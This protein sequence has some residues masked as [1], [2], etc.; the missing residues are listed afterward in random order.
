M[1]GHI[2]RQDLSGVIYRDSHANRLDSLR[3]LLPARPGKRDKARSPLDTSGLFST[4]MYS[5]LTSIYLKAHRTEITEDTLTSLMSDRDTTA[6]NCERFERLWKAETESRGESK[7]SL[8]RVIFRFIR[9]RFLAASLVLVCG[10][11]SGFLLTAFVLYLAI[12]YLEEPGVSTGYSV[13]LAFALFSSAACRVVGMNFMWYLNIRTAGRLRNALMMILYKKV[14]RL[15]SSSDISVGE[16][17][18]ICVNDMQRLYDA[19]TFLPVL[20][21]SPIFILLILIGCIL[22][23]GVPATLMGTIMLLL[24]IAIQG[25][26]AKINIRL[27]QKCVKLTDQRTRLMNEVLN[28][29][30]LIKMYAWEDIFSSNLSTIRQQECTYLQRAGYLG[31][32]TLGLVLSACPAVLIAAVVGNRLLGNDITAAQAFTLMQLFGSFSII[33][34]LLPNAIKPLSESVVSIQRIQPIL[35]MTESNHEWELPSDPGHALVIENASFSWDVP[36]TKERITEAEINSNTKYTLVIDDDMANADEKNEESVNTERL[37]SDENSKMLHRSLNAP[38]GQSAILRNISLIVPKSRLIGV[39]GSVGSGKSSLLASLLDQMYLLDGKVTLDGTFAFASQQAWIMNATVRDNILFGEEYNEERYKKAIF[40]CCLERDLE[41]MTDGDQTEIGERGVNVSGGQKQRIS[42]ARAYYSDRDIYLLDDPLSAV[43]AHVG[44]HIFNHCINGVLRGKTILFVTHQLQYLQECDHIIL[45]RDGGISEQGTHND[46][47]K[48]DDEYARLIDTFHGTVGE[49]GHNVQPK[50]RVGRVKENKSMDTDHGMEGNNN[51]VAVDN[52]EIAKLINEEDRGRGTVSFSTYRSFIQ[53][54]GGVCLAVTNVLLM[55]LAMLASIATTIWLSI[56]IQEMVRWKTKVIPGNATDSESPESP[57]PAYGLLP[58]NPAGDNAGSDVPP[59]SPI[60]GPNENDDNLSFYIPIYIGIFV[61][62]L[63]ILGIACVTYIMTLLRATTRIHDRLLHKIMRCPM[64]FFDTT[65]LGRILNRFSK[66]MDEVDLMLPINLM[67]ALIFLSVVLVIQTIIGIILPYYLI[68][69]ALVVIASSALYVIFRKGFCEI[70]RFDNTSRSKMVSH[71]S[72]TMQG[73]VSIR[74]YGQ[75]ERFM[76]RF[77]E[78]LDTNSHLLQLFGMAPRWVAVRMDI[79][80][81]MLVGV[82]ALLILLAKDTLFST[83]VASMALYQALLI[84]GGFLQELVISCTMTESSFISVERML[85][86]IE[87]TQSEADDH[88]EESKPDD[89]WPSSGDLKFQQVEMRYRPE[90]PLVL[91]GITCHIQPREKIGIVG[92]TGSG[93]SSLGVSLFRLV[94]NASGMILLDGVDIA[95]LGLHDLRSRLAVIPQD[96][97]LF[98]GSVR[99]NL[100]PLEKHS[101]AE[102]W[103]ALEKTYLKQTISALDSQLEATVIENG[104]NFSVGERQLMCMARV[105]LRNSKVL[106]MDE[107]TAAIDTETDSLIQ[108]TIRD[109]FKECTILI[110]AHRLN[111]ILDCDKIMVMEKG[112][113]VE[114]DTPKALLAD[115]ASQFSAMLEASEHN[116]GQLD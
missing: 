65:P 27:R 46:L 66:D 59:Y 100:D 64:A 93:K 81:A 17:V 84:S 32:Y 87:K 44:K 99:M 104:E 96:P 78:L 3:V 92:R 21:V 112:Q 89:S 22:V 9:T 41:I 54:A 34:Y 37:T 73:L 26:L 101:D 2:D 98:A 8:R 36:P 109:A 30:K 10:L 86:Y 43:D 68:I 19:V 62:A 51:I 110:I 40:S 97:V 79:M 53:Y 42:L 88:D 29:I 7:A 31:S 12:Q 35:M 5:F 61:L 63:S 69:F 67:R 90:L 115:P 111:T 116:K 91:K 55:F 94:E 60:D 113:I 103:D 1:E 95:S 48:A 70:K 24:F 39:V 85:E 16:M 13:A 76:A 71:I 57:T 107:A 75:S 52:D 23:V 105:L 74:A 45:M 20:F 11:T 56:W 80:A 6:V 114:L 108:Q 82:L 28:C 106:L 72:A 33:L 102:L 38:Q 15:R 77:K 18:N 47:I 50:S 14:L 49:D 83:V 25:R 4:L 58:F